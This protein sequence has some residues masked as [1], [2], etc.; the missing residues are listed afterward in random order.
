MSK[1]T[2]YRKKQ[3][4]ELQKKREKLISS[5]ESLESFTKKVQ[6]LYT[7]HPDFKLEP[8]SPKS[9]ALWKKY[10]QDYYD[11]LTSKFE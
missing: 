10:T 9:L 1:F 5:I 8:N 4:I 6:K 11:T 7:D 2:R 3:R